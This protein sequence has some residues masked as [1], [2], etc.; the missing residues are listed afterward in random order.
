M[1]PDDPGLNET[2]LET[3][4]E[5][6]AAE[7]VRVDEVTELVT[8]LADPN[9]ATALFNALKF[10]TLDYTDRVTL[11]RLYALADQTNGCVMSYY[12]DNRDREL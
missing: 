1:H 2:R 10:A 4:V 9:T 12:N 11:Q 7:L 8:V 6:H 3:S 5:K